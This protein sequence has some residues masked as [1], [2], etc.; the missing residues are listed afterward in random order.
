MLRLTYLSRSMCAVNRLT[1][2][3]GRTNKQTNKQI[4]MM[5]NFSLFIFAS[6]EWITLELVS[7]HLYFPMDG[8]KERNSLLNC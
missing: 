1:V 8:K 4:R 6:R 3:R 2:A 5:G 7:G